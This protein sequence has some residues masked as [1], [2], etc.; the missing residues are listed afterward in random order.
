MLEFLRQ[1]SHEAC[2]LFQH[3]ASEVNRF[4]NSKHQKKTFT[5]AKGSIAFKMGVIHT[6]IQSFALGRDDWA[7]SVFHLQTFQSQANLS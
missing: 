2:D 1:L 3:I 7:E 5:K 4:A 6:S